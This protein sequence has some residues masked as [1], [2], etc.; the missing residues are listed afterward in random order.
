MNI[1]FGD[2]DWGGEEQL[3]IVD[4]GNNLRGSVLGK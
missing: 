4:W 2:V 3:G 1:R